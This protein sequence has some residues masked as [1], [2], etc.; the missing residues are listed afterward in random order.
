MKKLI[1]FLIAISFSLINFFVISSNDSTYSVNIGAY[2]H[3]R[4]KNNNQN[5]KSKT[6]ESKSKVTIEDDVADEDIS[7]NMGPI[8]P[9]FYK[10]IYEY[11]KVKTNGEDSQKHS[12]Q[13]KETNKE[14]IKSAKKTSDNNNQESAKD[15]ERK[16][17]FDSINPN[18]GLEDYAGTIPQKVKD[19]INRLNS[20]K[21]AGADPLKMALLYGPPGTGKTTLVEIIARET[22][23]KLF[24]LVP[25]DFF[26]KYYGENIK[27]IK[28]VFASAKKESPS[29]VFIDE[30]DGM[31]AFD[32]TENT[33]RYRKD[34]CDALYSKL[35]LL[36]ASGSVCCIGAT[37][38]YA[39]ID[40]T[41][42][43]RM[44]GFCIAIPEPCDDARKA[45]LSH[46]LNKKKIDCDDNLKKAITARTEG[47]SGREIEKTVSC[48]FDVAKR[49]SNPSI[50]ITSEHLRIAFREALKEVENEKRIANP[51]IC[52]RTPY[53]DIPFVDLPGVDLLLENENDQATIKTRITQLKSFKKNY[54]NITT[55]L[56]ESNL[57]LYGPA[58]NGKTMLVEIIKRNSGFNMVYLNGEALLKIFTSSGK[59]AIDNI[60]NQIMNRTSPIILF[61]DEIEKVI[62]FFSRHIQFP[63]EYPLIS[64]IGETNQLDQINDSYKSKL[65]LIE[66][67]H[68]NWNQRAYIFGFYF[69]N[70][71]RSYKGLDT[72][73]DDELITYATKLSSVTGGTIWGSNHFSC[74]DI[75]NIFKAAKDMYDAE[76]EPTDSPGFL[77]R[78]WSFNYTP[79]NNG[80]TSLLFNWQAIRHGVK[81]T[82]WNNLIYM[83]FEKQRKQVQQ[84]KEGTNAPSNVGA[85]V[86][87]AVINKISR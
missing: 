1:L 16:T 83:A 34:L 10:S 23:R 6:N 68:P 7:L 63:K 3:R 28:N 52:Y 56:P 8:D 2:I 5:N 39:Q 79:I 22:R 54:P 87:N 48:A 84:Y 15:E 62:S 77:F 35:D 70:Y 37:N 66:L 17:C 55:Q 41:A 82:K 9:T 42:K 69:I 44:R 20:T 45:I 43:T 26:D 13:N 30:I 53:A 58:G 25:S 47:W 50:T 73:T 19:L 40:N 81:D 11:A 72:Q 38:K 18:K 24:K 64:L 31:L 51:H 75:E 74:R 86:T 4:Y 12:G 60:L 85:T 27:K 14:N 71:Q 33:S 65:N 29:I 76:I 49:D 32:E 46:Y 36:P 21:D 61:I 78:L 80:L 57:L 59:K 67:S